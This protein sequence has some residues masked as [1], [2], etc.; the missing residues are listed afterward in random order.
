MACSKK[1]KFTKAVS[2]LDVEQGIDKGLLLANGFEYVKEDMILLS[3]AYGDTSLTYGFYDIDTTENARPFS[4]ILSFKTKLKVKK[5]NDLF[6]SEG[7]VVHDLQE[8]NNG[9]FQFIVIDTIDN[10]TFYCSMQNEESIGITFG[11]DDV[12]E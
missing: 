6:K 5:I 2:I 1:R 3:K 10:D 12:L 8:Y 7:G 9:Y 11:Y 4:R